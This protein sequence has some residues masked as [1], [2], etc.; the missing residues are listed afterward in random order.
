M[1]G[2]TCVRR[3]RGRAWVNSHV[4]RDTRWSRRGDIRL[5]C[6]NCPKGYWGSFLVCN[7]QWHARWRKSGSSVEAPNA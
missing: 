1:G 3:E 2:E 6:Q 7:A 5:T 4:G